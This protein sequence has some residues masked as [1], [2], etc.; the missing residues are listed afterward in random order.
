MQIVLRLGWLFG[1]LWVVL[2]AIARP[3]QATIQVNLQD[4]AKIRG[5]VRVS[6]VVQTELLV[7][8]VEFSVDGVLRGVDDSTP[9]EY[10]WDT[11]TDTEGEHVLKITAIL[12]GN[13]AITKQIKL[14]I[15]NEVDK[16][17]DYHYQ[18]ARELFVNGQFEK[19]IEHA[20]VALKAGSAHREAR[21]LLIQAYLRLGRVREA[22]EATEDLVRLY[23]E[24]LEAQEFR[25]VAS[26][27]R[28]RT[29]RNERP[30]LET[31]IE[32]RHKA[33]Q[34]RLQA[35]ANAA[36]SEAIAQRVLIQIQEGNAHSVISD[37]IVLTQR[38]E[39]DP[40][41]L[42][43]LAY[44]YLQAG[45]WRDVIVATDTAIRRGAA[46]DYTYAIRGLAASLLNDERAREA[47]FEQAEKLDKNSKALRA[48]RA[49]LAMLDRRVVTVAR[50]TAQAQDRSDNSPQVAFMRYWSFVVNREFDR[51]RDAFWRVL[52][53]DPLFAEVYTLRG[54][55]NLADGL[56]PG[57]E[58]LLT[59]AREWF[60]LGARARPNYAPAQ[61]GIALSYAFQIYVARGDGQKPDES[62]FTKAQEALAKAQ[63]ITRDP[64]WMQIGSA[65]VL[66]QLGKGREADRAM[67]IANRLD[68]QRVGSVRPPDPPRLIELLQAFLFVPM[69][70]AP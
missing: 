35:L 30:L 36:T 7:Q 68:P 53:L 27:R 28:A 25:I 29:A 18:Q 33:N 26:L 8:R 63:A 54:L 3:S 14:I 66:D 70:Q 1:L 44:A 62:L 13:K 60:E 34:I 69:I 20:R 24:S 47:A 52:E 38:E 9:Y 21:I 4:S 45:R 43:L 64:I 39:R 5:I 2:P 15:D 22:D 37:L 40:R 46:N 17:A 59:V 16:G 57:E 42:N 6:A 50:L 55:V 41:F 61:L 65:F 23:P 51:S 19:A 11:L 56:R 49:S 12:E 48:A 58:D 32:A 67:Q 31:A 10:E